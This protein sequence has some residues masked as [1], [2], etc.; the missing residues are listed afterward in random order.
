ML[1]M[2]LC[3]S[4]QRMVQNCLW[5][6]R[7]LSDTATQAVG[8]TVT[9]VVVDFVVGIVGELMSLKAIYLLTGVDVDDVDWC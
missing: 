8:V 6:L 1:A 7:N 3:N 5:T 9:V 4:S 2:H